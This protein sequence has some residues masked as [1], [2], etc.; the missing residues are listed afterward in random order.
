[1]PGVHPLDF[2]RAS[3]CASFV[4]SDDLAF[5]MGLFPAKAWAQVDHHT[6]H[7]ALGLYDAHAVVGFRR[8]LILSYDGGGNDGLLRAFRGNVDENKARRLTPLAA[9]QLNIGNRYNEVGA[10][11]PEVN[12]R[13]CCDVGSRRGGPECGVVAA[14]GFCDYSFHLA[15]LVSRDDSA[16]W[17]ALSGRLMGYA[18]LGTPKPQLVEMFRRLFAEEH[19]AKGNAMTSGSK[20]ERDVRI[21]IAAALYPSILQRHSAAGNNTKHDGTSHEAKAEA[22]YWSRTLRLLQLAQGA[23]DK[24]FSA[25]AGSN[26]ETVLESYSLSRRHQRDLAASAQR[27]MEDVVVGLIADILSQH[28]FSISSTFATSSDNDGNLDDSDGQFDGIVITGGCALNVKVNS[29]IT[30]AF[31]R[32]PVYVPSAP[33]DCGLSFGQAWVA[34][35]PAP[36]AK[37]GA[38]GHGASPGPSVSSSASSTSFSSPPDYNTSLA[39]PLPWWSAGRDVGSGASLEGRLELHRLGWPLFDLEALGGVA[40]ALGAENLREASEG[41]TARVAALLAGGHIIGVARGNSDHGPRAL[42]ARS[43]LAAP[44]PGVKERLNALKAREWYRPVAPVATEEEAD[45]SFVHCDGGKNSGG[46]KSQQRPVRSPYMSFAPRL[47]QPDAGTTIPE[48]SQSCHDN[49]HRDDHEVVEEKEAKKWHQNVGGGNAFTFSAALSHFD[50]TARVQTVGRGGSSGGG[51]DVWLWSLLEAVGRATGRALLINTSF[52]T[53]GRPILNTASEA[54][55]LLRDCED[56]DFV[57]LEH[58]LFSKAHVASASRVKAA[59]GIIGG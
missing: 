6:S 23:G 16:A 37:I 45:R 36:R 54:L 48:Y 18:A 30:E 19:D 40:Q 56:L 31:P 14:R 33:S 7:A 57:V 3:F 49:N 32:L 42:G 20:A 1:M 43:L 10:L 22:F 11:L 12:R 39:T 28:S 2:P 35:P 59:L 50:G 53:K 15:H 41:G 24:A 47:R 4:P 51:G 38:L 8:P 55:A 27:A 26:L 5:I 52:N 46:Q 13:A 58:W 9:P 44:L 25:A 17:L 21:R 29:R 34:A